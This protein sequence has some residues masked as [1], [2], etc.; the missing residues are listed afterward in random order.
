MTF[1]NVIPNIDAKALAA[2]DIE[3]LEKVH[4]AAKNIG[5]MT[6]SNT[7]ISADEVQKTLDM[8]RA[9]FK[10]D[11]ENKQAVDMSATGSNRGW[12]G[13]RSE[14]VNPNANPDYKEVFDCGVEVAMDDPQAH[15][16]VYAPNHWPSTPAEFQAHIKNYY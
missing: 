6:L 15:L 16:S 13:S 9:F 5:F 14:Q 11:K 1:E 3:T 7:V 12:G 8:Y 10:G 4:H 2:R